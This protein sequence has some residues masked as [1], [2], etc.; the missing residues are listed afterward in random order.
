MGAPSTVKEYLAARV[1]P[2]FADEVRRMAEAESETQSTIIRRLLRLGLEAARRE[3]GSG[4]R[5]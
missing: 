1:V 4:S 3:Q 5:G 2:A